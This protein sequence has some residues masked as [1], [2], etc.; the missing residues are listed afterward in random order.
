MR[1]HKPVELIRNIPSAGE[2]GAF[3]AI[4]KFD[5]HTGID[6]YCEDGTPVYAVEDGVIVSIEDFTGPEAGSPWWNST[7][8]VL[9]E[10]DNGVIVYGEIEPDGMQIGTHV[11]GGMPLGF[12]KQVLK[13][14]KGVTPTSML[15]FEWLKHGTRQTY[16]WYH[17]E[18]KP[19][20]LLDPTELI[21]RIY[22]Q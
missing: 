21:G 13:K 8:A 15:H 17:D 4:R 16:W 9:I 20:N 2:P 14:D 1:L 11:I 18:G 3:G 6:L 12:V 5:I 7:K 19:D 10:G 22:G